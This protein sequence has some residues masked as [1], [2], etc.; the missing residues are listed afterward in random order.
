MREKSATISPDSGPS[1]AISA[2]PGGLE[3]QSLPC[4]FGA[5]GADEVVEGDDAGPVGSVAPRGGRVGLPLVVVVTR[6]ARLEELE[7]GARGV[8]HGLDPGLLV[9]DGDVDR[10]GAPAVH[11]VDD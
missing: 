8:E 9:R 1:P 4:P 10:T 11:L 5:P 2:A 7:V 3:D 6:G